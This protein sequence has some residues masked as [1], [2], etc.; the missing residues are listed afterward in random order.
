MKQVYLY[1]TVLVILFISCQRRKEYPLVTLNTQ[2]GETEFILHKETP[3]HKKN[4]IALYEERL[5]DSSRFHRI[6]P[7]FF[8]EASQVK[9]IKTPI[10]LKAINSE[11]IPKLFH[12]RGAITAHKPRG[13][14]NAMGKSDPSQFYIIQGR[15][16]TESELQA[17]Q[18]NYNY[19]KLAPLMSKL[20]SSRKYP[21]LSQQAAKLQ[22]NQ[23]TAGMKKWVLSQQGEIEKIF[24]KQYLKQFS[25]AQ[26][27]AYTTIGGLPELDGE[28]TVFGQVTSGLASLDSLMSISTNSINAPITP[29]YFTTKISYLS[30]E[31]FDTLKAQTFSTD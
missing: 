11:S 12:K 6:L 25:P 14:S 22:F 10:N 20:L 29:S 18:D 21:Q 26:I 9:P 16:H 7:S 5:L 15:I 17:I 3:N 19:Q 30:Q 13:L 1:S 31:A 8:I 24:G 27:K 4:F 28:Y 23:N 2:F